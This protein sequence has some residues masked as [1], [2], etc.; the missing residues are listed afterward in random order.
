MEGSTFPPED[1]WW[2]RKASTWMEMEVTE[3]MQNLMTPAGDVTST[4]DLEQQRPFLGESPAEGAHKY[5][6]SG[7]NGMP[8]RLDAS[9]IVEEGR[10]KTRTKAPETTRATDGVFDEGVTWDRRCA[11]KARPNT[12]TFE[13]RTI[14]KDAHRLVVS[15]DDVPK[16]KLREHEG[17]SGFV[18]RIRVDGMH[19][20]TNIGRSVNV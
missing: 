13:R 16:N 19:L 5:R 2:Y 14:V 17:G 3:P 8:A 4:S 12:I 18:N 11:S 1:R 10:P 9:L 6:T 7:P 20:P 15:P